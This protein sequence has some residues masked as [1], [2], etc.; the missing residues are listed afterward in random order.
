ML[1]IPIV[2]LE[3]FR[4]LTIVTCVYAAVATMHKSI[5]IPNMASLKR[6]FVLSLVRLAV[7]R[8]LIRNVH[9]KT[10]VIKVL[11]INRAPNDGKVPS[12]NTLGENSVYEPF[13]RTPQIN[14]TK[15]RIVSKGSTV[16]YALRVL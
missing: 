14:A 4:K 3:L 7:M 13:R 16:R 11:T 12:A 5:S 6:A 2:R 15:V 9:M 8:P 1:Y 10:S